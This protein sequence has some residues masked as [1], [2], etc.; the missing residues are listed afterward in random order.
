MIFIRKL[1]LLFDKVS[2][3]IASWATWDGSKDGSATTIPAGNDI[4]D[5]TNFD[6]DRSLVA[7]QDG[8]TGQINVIVAATNGTVVAYPTAPA[9]IDAGALYQASIAALDTSRVLVSYITGT[10]IWAVVVSI[11]GSNNI[12]VNAPKLIFAAISTLEPRLLK[13]ASNQCILTYADESVIDTFSATCITTTGTTVDDPYTITQIDAFVPLL[14]NITL[15]SSD[16]A[17]VAYSSDELGNGINGIVLTIASNIVSVFS[18]NSLVSSSIP[19]FGLLSCQALDSRNVV[20]VYSDD[21]AALGMAFVVSIIDNSG[22][23]SVGDSVIFY[24]GTVSGNIDGSSNPL[25]FI[26]SATVM[27]FFS[28]SIPSGN[29]CVLSVNENTITPH[30]P[31]TLVNQVYSEICGVLLDANRILS[32]GRANPTPGGQTQVLSII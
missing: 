17:F 1:V 25:C 4:L 12:T 27:V 19:T 9:L 31:V 10:G 28:T 20:V 2:S 18:P 13:L 24:N 21:N 23:M 8:N 7:Y 11:D 22:D 16:S 3:A 5:I 26:D 15:L 29:A 14:S 6:T 30:S 32:A